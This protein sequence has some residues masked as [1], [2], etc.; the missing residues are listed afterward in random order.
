M[1]KIKEFPC[2]YVRLNIIAVNY[3][4][5]NYLKHKLLTVL[6]VGGSSKKIKLLGFECLKMLESF[7]I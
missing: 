6:S 7:K 4:L 5:I 1:M 2:C 3:V